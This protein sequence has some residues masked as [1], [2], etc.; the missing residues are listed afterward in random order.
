MRYV[1]NWEVGKIRVE[2]NKGEINYIIASYLRVHG[3]EYIKL[4][5]VLIYYIAQMAIWHSVE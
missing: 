3:N 5:D 4:A 1:K 2:C